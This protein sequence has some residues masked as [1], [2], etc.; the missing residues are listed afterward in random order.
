MSNVAAKKAAYEL[1]AEQAARRQCEERM[2]AIEQELKDVT[3][4]CKLLEEDNKV[5]VAELDKGLTRG[6]R[7]TVQV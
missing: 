6:E 2:S 3:G 4:K 5:K 7:S 1:K